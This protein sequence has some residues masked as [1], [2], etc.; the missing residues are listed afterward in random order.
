MFKLLPVI[1]FS[2]ILF[3]CTEVVFEAPQPPGAENLSSIPDVLVGSYSFVVLNEQ[4]AIHITKDYFDGDEGGKKYLSDSLILRKMGNKYVI[5]QLINKEGETKGKWSVYTFEEKG[6][7]F[8]KAT[9][10]IIS[11]DEYLPAFIKAHSATQVGGGQEKQLIIN[12]ENKKAF[13][14]ISKDKNASLAIIL[15][16]MEE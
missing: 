6:C 16:K 5:N 11:D 1:V 3:S 10:F 7:G 8:L 9:A 2:I 13:E 12:P 14:K 15:E 4:E